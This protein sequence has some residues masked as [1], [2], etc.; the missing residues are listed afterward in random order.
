MPLPKIDDT[1]DAMSVTHWISILNVV[2]S[3][4]LGLCHLR[5]EEVLPCMVE[6]SR[7]NL[8]VFYV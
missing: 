8:I 2:D 1:L 3:G 5:L 6:E 4:R 7:L